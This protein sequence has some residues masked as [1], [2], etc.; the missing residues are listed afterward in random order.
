MYGKAILDSSLFQIKNGKNRFSDDIKKLDSKEF[1]NFR[2]LFDRL[3]EL[4]KTAK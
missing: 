2:I 1:E 3:E 4:V